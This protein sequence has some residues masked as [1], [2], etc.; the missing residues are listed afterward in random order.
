MDHQLQAQYAS[1]KLSI[2]VKKK[3][4]QEE[5]IYDPEEILQTEELELHEQDSI[6][7]DK[8]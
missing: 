1:N 5:T 3:D 8:H 2:P 7:I 4:K 6:I